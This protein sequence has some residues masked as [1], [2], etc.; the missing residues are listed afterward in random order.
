LNK[1]NLSPIENACLKPVMIIYL[2][3]TLVLDLNFNNEVVRRARCIIKHVFVFTDLRVGFVAAWLRGCGYVI[4][5]SLFV[6]LR[7]D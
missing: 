7:I 5:V 2:S 1:K 6:R 3:E 4:M